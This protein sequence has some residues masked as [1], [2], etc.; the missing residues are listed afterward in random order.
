MK[1]H[2]SVIVPIY[3]E[4]QILAELVPHLIDLKAFETIIVDGGSTDGTWQR[5]GDLR[6]G[7]MLCLR[8]DKGRAL[9]MNTGAVHASGNVLLFL[10]ADT[11]LPPGALTLIDETLNREPERRWGRF[12]VRFDHAG[13]SLQVVAEAMNLRSECTSICTGDQGIFVYR[14][15]FLKIGGFAPIPL[16]EDVDLSRRL[17]RLSSP[18]RIREAVI[19]SSRRWTTH[20]VWRTIVLMWWLRWLYWWGVPAAVLA[21]RYYREQ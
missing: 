5:L 11:Q 20:G 15:E 2:I 13:P 6:T 7:S 10:H 19:T 9:Q 8:A 16:M 17:K 21:E 1:Q 3:N 12:D 18:L 14:D 4:S